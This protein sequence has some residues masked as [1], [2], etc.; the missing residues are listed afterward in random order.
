L[1]REEAKD[2]KADEDNK[3]KNKEAQEEIGRQIVDSA[4]KVHKTLGPGLL[5]SAYQG[6]L[7]YELRKRK[8]KVECEVPQPVIYDGLTI[9]VGYRIDMVVEGVVIIENK[10]VENFM[11]VH[12]AQILTYMKLYHC[13]LGY[14]LNWNV[15]L[16]KNGIKRMVYHH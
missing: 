8:L 14:L 11:P 6:C 4:V 3:G 2:A 13:S 12:E 5:E 10:N 16:M 1:N 7:A 15:P 9:D